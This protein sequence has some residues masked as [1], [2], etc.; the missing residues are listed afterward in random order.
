MIRSQRSTA[1]GRTGDPRLIADEFGARERP[2]KN[3]AFSYFPHDAKAGSVPDPRV[4]RGDALNFAGASH[5]EAVFGC[6]RV[7]GNI[8]SSFTCECP[9][10]A[11]RRRDGRAGRRLGRRPDRVGRWRSRRLH[12]RAGH[13]VKLGRQGTPALP[14]RALSTPSAAIDSARSL[15]ANRVPRGAIWVC[16]RD[17]KNSRSFSKRSF[18]SPGIPSANPAAVTL[19]MATLA[20][21]PSE[22]VLAALTLAA[23]PFRTR[24]ALECRIQ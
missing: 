15:A 1:Y 2:E 22:L 11:W 9:G 4:R 10:A 17:L 5:D 7:R 6:R 16:K 3:T 20:A 8:V 24:S 23:A 19:A 21:N 14:P 12:G 13:C 18:P